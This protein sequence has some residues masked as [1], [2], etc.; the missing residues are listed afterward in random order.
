MA[1]ILIVDDSRIM[2]KNIASILIK[3]GHTIVGEAADGAEAHLMYRTHIPDLVTMDITMSGVNGIDAVRLIMREFPK[4]KIVMVSALTQRN[5]VFEA[6]EL[7]AKHYLIK[8]VTYDSVITIVQKV[9]GIEPVNILSN[10]AQEKP[11]IEVPNEVQESQTQ[12]PFTIESIDNTFKIKVTK[13]LTE[14]SA[15]SLQQAVQGLLF[16]KPL[17]ITIDFGNIGFFPQSFL[18]KFGEIVKSIKAVNGGI[19]LIAQNTN[20]L[21]LLRDKKIDDLLNQIPTSFHSNS[22]PTGDVRNS[23]TPS[24]E[25]NIVLGKLFPQ[26]HGHYSLESVEPSDKFIYLKKIKCPVCDS[27]IEIQSVRYTKLAIDKVDLDFRRHFVGFEP[28]WYSVQ[29]CPHCKYVSLI[30]DF[31]KITA[32]AQSSIQQKLTELKSGIEGDFATKRT[33]DQ[34]FTLYY[35]ALH[36]IEGLNN[37]SQESKLWLRLAWLYDD[38]AELELSKM[39]SEKA[40]ILYKDLFHN[41]RSQTTVEQ[42]QRMTMLLAE[43]CV[44]NGLISEAQ[45]YFRDTIVHKGGNKV[46][47]ETAKDRMHDIRA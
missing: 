12:Q 21:Q 41:S 31:D 9:L 1:R 15:K 17:N 35:L 25:T 34:V 33:I 43:L 18:E 14:E 6:L 27:Q 36:C 13:Y 42:D 22:E 5:M 16:V 32:K 28:L 46:M 39:A 40:L 8:P 7:G 11:P 38:V 37:K 24:S 30:E 47:N 45:Q 20:L 3:G 26:N 44:R 4:A 10:V 29:I 19:K 23:S 2:R